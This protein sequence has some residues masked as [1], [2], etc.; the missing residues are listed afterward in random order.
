MNVAPGQRRHRGHRASGEH[1]QRCGRPWPRYLPGRRASPWLVG[2]ARSR[3]RG[4]HAGHQRGHDPTYLL[5]QARG[6]F[7]VGE[8]Q[9]VGGAEEGEG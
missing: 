7:P 6:V 1:R 8:D 2:T 3:L 9:V 5:L 4:V